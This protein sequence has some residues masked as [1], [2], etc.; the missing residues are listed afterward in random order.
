LIN[1]VSAAAVETVR[2]YDVAVVSSVLSV[3]G[4]AKA[5]IEI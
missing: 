1:N 3:G 5:N 4:G 2:T